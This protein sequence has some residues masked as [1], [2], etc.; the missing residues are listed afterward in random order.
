[1]LPVPLQ[2]SRYESSSFKH[3]LNAS[4]NGVRAV[5]LPAVILEHWVSEF[6]EPLRTLAKNLDTK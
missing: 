3:K 6:P 2:P 5:A 1:M 4:P